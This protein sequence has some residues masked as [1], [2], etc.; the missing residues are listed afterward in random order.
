[1]TELIPVKKEQK[2]EL[3]SLLISYFEEVDKSKILLVK[4]SKTLEYPYL[5]LYWEDSTRHPF[6]ISQ[7]S[8]IVGFVL[9]NSITSF[10]EFNAD[11]S[12]AEFYILPEFRRNGIG[13]KIA[14]MIFEQ[15]PGKWEVKQQINNKKAIEFWRN[16]IA[17]YT[18]QRF[19]EVLIEDNGSAEIFQLFH[20][21]RI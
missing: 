2:L 18:K 12:I 14:M 9:I 7:D 21:S 19:K 10:Q 11:Y 13:K 6:F 15:Y 1:M 16:T 20:S 8:Q 17:S 5:D 4:N 3:K